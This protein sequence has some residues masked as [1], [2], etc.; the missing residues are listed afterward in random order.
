[1]NLR[2]LADIAHFSNQF[3]SGID[4]EDLFFILEIF[5]KA[6]ISQEYGANNN[7]YE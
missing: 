1:M 7:K 6:Y 4:T 5:F 3:A 2:N